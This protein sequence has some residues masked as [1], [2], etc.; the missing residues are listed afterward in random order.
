MKDFTIHP[1]CHLTWGEIFK[2]FLADFLFGLHWV[3]IGWGDTEELLNP[4]ELSYL[5][6]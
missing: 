3:R 4:F 1:K 6:L 2:I 5:L